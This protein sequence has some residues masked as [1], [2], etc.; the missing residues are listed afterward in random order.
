MSLIERWMWMEVGDIMTPSASA[1]RVTV[2][3]TYQ[4][5][6][7]QATELPTISSN[8]RGF[9]TATKKESRVTNKDHPASATKIGPEQIW[10]GCNIL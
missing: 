3:P 10:R 1:H 7:G 5:G 8:R 4:V 9:D 6:A 2:R